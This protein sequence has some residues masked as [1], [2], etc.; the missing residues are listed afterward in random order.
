MKTQKK[1]NS[2]VSFIALF[3]I[4]VLVLQGMSL[5]A[6]G[7]AGAGAPAR[8][9]DDLSSPE[10]VIVA[11]VQDT[12]KVAESVEAKDCPF[13]RHE[14]NVWAGGGY[15]SLN[16]FPNYGDR[17]YRFGGLLGAGY[18]FH[19]NPHW[20]LS[21]G[22]EIAL[23]NMKMKVND[24]VDSNPGFDPDGKVIT[25]YAEFKNY[26]EKQRLYQLQIPLQLWFQ[27]RVSGRGDELYLSLGGKFGLPLSAQYRIK[28]PEFSTYG[29]YFSTNQP[30]F[31]QIDLGY[32]DHTG[33][34]MKEKLNFDFSYIGSAEAGVKWKMQSKRYNLYTGFYFDYGFNNIL[35]SNDNTFLTYDQNFPDRFRTNSV[36][37]SQYTK[38]NETK[39]FADKLSVVALGVKV[40][41]GFNLCHIDKDSDKDGVPDSRDKCPRT[42]RGVQVDE[43]GCPL[44]SDGDGVPDYL[45]KCPNTPQGVQVDK[46]GCP[47]GAAEQQYGAGARPA[48][49]P[50]EPTPDRRGPFYIGDPLLE[51]EMR[52]AS[53]EYG[54][55]TDLLVLYVD[56]YEINQTELSPIM[57]RMIDDKIRLLQRYNT[58]NYII[59][60]EGHTCDL[61]REDFNMRLGQM[62]AEVVREY[63]M[64][65]G[66]NGN[67]IIPTSKGKTSPIVPNTS[68]ANRK[69]NRRV[70]FLIK[71]KR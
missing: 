24:L 65:K 15:S 71:E 52:R 41:L 7:Q 18:A 31:D 2:R 14:F 6:Q 13:C 34:K 32:G 57:K 26:T 42:P 3:A 60:A 55:L 69:L 45:D 53:Q 51:A 62:R 5:Q 61:G 56:G 35:K 16:T 47:Y 11:T 39:P 30:L 58:P 48:V 27:T 68:E 36:L 21:L 44:D 22:A 4:M 20:A 23:Y 1:V 43:D 49:R 63:L 9:S 28:N 67:N 12:S 37:T 70:V 54:Q 29:H 50:N 40:R 46:D 38:D 64:S 17:R 8:S 25:Y 59:I 33:R 66:F 10:K 19:F